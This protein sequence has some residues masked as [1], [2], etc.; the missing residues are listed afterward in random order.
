MLELVAAN[1]KVSYTG[2]QPRK[3]YLHALMWW[4]FNDLQAKANFDIGSLNSFATV[5]LYFQCYKIGYWNSSI[6]P[7]VE[8]HTAT[9]INTKQILII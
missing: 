9:Y 1:F 6:F 2:P 5:D 7:V 8:E 4:T 3:L